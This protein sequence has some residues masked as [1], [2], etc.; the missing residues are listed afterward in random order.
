W[1]L[2]S[3][4]CMRMTVADISADSLR[5]ARTL[6][7]GRTLNQRVT[8]AVADGLEALTEPVDVV[9][10]A[11]MGA[12]TMLHILTAGQDQLADAVLVLQTH[13]DHDP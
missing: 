4:R 6:F 5:K 3:N 10:I 11:G 9:I 2:E 7:E 8:F 12:Q 1:L 13:T